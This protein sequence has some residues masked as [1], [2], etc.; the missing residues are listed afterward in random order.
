MH[1]R[2][3]AEEFE[4]TGVNIVRICVMSIKKLDTDLLFLIKLNELNTELWCSKVLIA[5]YKAYITLVENHIRI[6]IR[7]YLH[8]KICKF[9]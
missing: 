8:N 6:C 1:L 9:F 3:S 5:C 7:I 2:F 4:T